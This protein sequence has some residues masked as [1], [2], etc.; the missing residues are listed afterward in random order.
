VGQPAA[1]HL[2]FDEGGQLTGVIQ[3]AV[4]IV[5]V[6]DLEHHTAVFLNDVVDDL[7]GDDVGRVAVHAD[8]DGVGG[9]RDVATLP[10]DTLLAGSCLDAGM[11]QVRQLS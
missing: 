3:H 4:L 11:L 1:E 10:Q 9:Q 6:F 8:Q 2:I 5:A 7:E